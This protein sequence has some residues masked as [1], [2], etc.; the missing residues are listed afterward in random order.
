MLSLP[1]LCAGYLL[2]VN[3]LTFALYSADKRRARR[4]DWRI[5]EATLLLLAIIGGS[6]GA[7]L[8]MRHFRHKTRHGKFRYG[9]PLILLLQLALV[10]YII[11]TKVL[12]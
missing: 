7:L 12:A 2:L 3:L 6:V 5:S 9:V 4:G 8:G 1:V 10:L 11:W